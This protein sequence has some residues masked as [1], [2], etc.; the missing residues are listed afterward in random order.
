MFIILLACLFCF[1]DFVVSFSQFLLFCVFFFI[2]QSYESRLQGPDALHLPRGKKYI[3][4]DTNLFI[5]KELH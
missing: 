5:S 1:S 2:M 3:A 4:Y